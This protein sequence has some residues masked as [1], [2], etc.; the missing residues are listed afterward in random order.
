MYSGSE[1]G[2]VILDKWGTDSGWRWGYGMFSSPSSS[3]ACQ[4]R[5][6]IELTLLYY[7]CQQS[8]TLLPPW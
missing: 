1:V 2:G 4:L 7:L 5:E 8:S 6:T 3:F